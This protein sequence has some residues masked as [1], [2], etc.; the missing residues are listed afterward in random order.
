MLKY[1]KDIRDFVKSC[2]LYCKNF[3]SKTYEYSYDVIHEYDKVKE[4]K[5]D[6]IDRKLN[7]L[8][9]QLESSVNQFNAVAKSIE[10]SLRNTFG[11]NLLRSR[12]DTSDKITI[13]DVKT[14]VEI[15]DEFNK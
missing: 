3:E 2:K 11:D 15:Y 8:D 6:S 10:A 14:Y 7:Y 1:Q 13:F 12:L 9:K 4:I 5:K